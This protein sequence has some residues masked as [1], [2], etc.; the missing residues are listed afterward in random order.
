ME[1]N[2]QYKK[3]RIKLNDDDIKRLI[4]G[5]TIEGYKTAIQKN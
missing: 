2:Y 4:K 3:I 1:E 5:E